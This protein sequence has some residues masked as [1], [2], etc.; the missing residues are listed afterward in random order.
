MS[1]VMGVI[2][3]TTDGRG[4]EVTGEGRADALGLANRLCL[5]AAPTFAIMRAA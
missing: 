5:A 1:A 3:A 2:G 4:R